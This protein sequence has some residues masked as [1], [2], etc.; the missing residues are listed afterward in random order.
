MVYS[1]FIDTKVRGRLLLHSVPPEGLSRI[2]EACSLIFGLGNQ[3]GDADILT[4][5]AWPSNLNGDGY[6]IIRGVGIRG[7]TPPNGAAFFND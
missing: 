4:T 1:V 5:I 3:S 7:L 2:T 6:C